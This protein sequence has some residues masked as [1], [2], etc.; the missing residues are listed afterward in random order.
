M[1]LGFRAKVGVRGRVRACAVGRGE[2]DGDL[3]DLQRD[4]AWL[5][6]G[7]GLVRVRVRVRV[8]VGFRVR[9]GVRVGTGEIVPSV[10]TLPSDTEYSKLSTHLPRLRCR[11]QEVA[12]AITEGGVALVQPGWG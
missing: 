8:R 9:V 2:V 4:R 11:P 10:V 12:I 7:V 6:V 3:D 1:G 5:G